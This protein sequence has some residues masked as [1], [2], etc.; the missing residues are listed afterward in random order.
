MPSQ[1]ALGWNG[2]SA[3]SGNRAGTM[4]LSKYNSFNLLIIVDLNIKDS[5]NRAE[6][7]YL[8]DSFNISFNIIY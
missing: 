4:T 6:I 3:I 8:K 5:F 7:L 1:G 2:A